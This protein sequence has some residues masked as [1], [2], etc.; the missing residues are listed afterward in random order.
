MR[1]DRTR[2]LRTALTPSP[3]PPNLCGCDLDAFLAAL[4]EIE[5]GLQYERHG[6]YVAHLDD[7]VFT[8]PRVSFPGC[9]VLDEKSLGFILDRISVRE[10]FRRIG[11]AHLFDPS[12]PASIRKMQFA[13]INP[14]GFVGY[15]FGE[16][17]LS[18]LGYYTPRPKHSGF[19]L[20]SGAQRAAA[21]SEMDGS[22]FLHSGRHH[23]VQ[24]APIGRYAHNA[25]DGSFTGKNGIS[26]LEDLRTEW[27]Q[28][29]VIREALKMTATELSERL[30]GV[31]LECNSLFPHIVEAEISRKL[32]KV[33]IVCTM[34]GTVAAAHL[35]GVPAT[36]AFLHCGELAW[37]EFGTCIADYMAEFSRFSF[38]L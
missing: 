17:L 36:V 2:G 28:E 14:L 13:A 24:V 35:C 9:A 6:W 22:A 18:R 26:C 23:S 8:Y 38:Q 37:D 33:A 7:C 32:P 27:A 31:N 29:L 5:S 4:L 1:E 11:V 34:I 12:E 19:S 25:W 30:R 15:Q 10:Y 21:T 16:P 20:G 3:S